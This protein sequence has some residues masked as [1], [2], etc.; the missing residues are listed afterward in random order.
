MPLLKLTA[1][2]GFKLTAKYILKGVASTLP[3]LKHRIGTIS[4]DTAVESAR[5]VAKWLES[6]V[7]RILLV[8]D[9]VETARELPQDEIPEGMDV[10]DLKDKVKRDHIDI[11]A[12][13]C[14]EIANE[15]VTPGVDYLF[16]L[17]IH[18]IAVLGLG[19][20]SRHVSLP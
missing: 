3:E 8:V 18:P 5:R 15:N 11:L 13:G 2:T 6:S 17:A 7:G 14:K 20:Y 1:E 10:D 16:W 4:S 9:E 19:P 12:Q